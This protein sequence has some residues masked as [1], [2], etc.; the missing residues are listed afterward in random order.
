MKKTN[1][2]LLSKSYST[3]I[4]FET[5]SNDKLFCLRAKKVPWLQLASLILFYQIVGVGGFLYLYD[6][7]N[8]VN[9]KALIPIILTLFTGIIAFAM[10]AG[11]HYYERKKGAVLIYYKEVKKIVLPRI[12]IE[13]PLNDVYIEIVNGWVGNDGDKDNIAELQLVHKKTNRRWLLLSR[14]ASWRSNFTDIL[15]SIQTLTPIE[16]KK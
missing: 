3:G 11:K 2:N 4:Y 7:Q 9:L 8:G 16:I 15:G 1:N 5:Y 14:F 12:K 13:F 6:S 10:V